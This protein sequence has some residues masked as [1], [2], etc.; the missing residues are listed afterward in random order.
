MTWV[1]TTTGKR[2]GMSQH[3]FS[4]TAGIVFLLVAIAHLARIVFGVPLVVRY[5]SSDVG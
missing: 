4:L 1:Y 3:G 5:L 2:A